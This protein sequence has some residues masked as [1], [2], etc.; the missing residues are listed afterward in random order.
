MMKNLVFGYI[1]TNVIDGSAIFMSSL[2]NVLSKNKSSH[3]NILLAVPLKRNTI[4]K[5][6]DAIKNVAIIDPYNDTDYEQFNLFLREQISIEEAANLIVY[7]DEL[8][9]YNRIFIRSLEVTKKLLEIKPNIIKKTFSYITGITSSKQN[10]NQTNYGYL[11]EIEKYGGKLLCQTKEMKQHIINQLSLSDETIIDLN[12]MIPD[13]P[14]DYDDIFTKKDVYNKFVYTGKFA[15]EWNTLPMINCYRE[16]QETHEAELDVAGDQFK[17]DPENDKFES[18]SRYLLQ[19]TGYLKWYGA[20]SRKQSLTLVKNSDVGLSWRSEKLDDSLELSTKVLEYCSLGKPP[21]INKTNMHIKIFGDDYPFYCNN[22]QSFIEAM[23]YAIENPE[24][25]EKYSKKVFEISKEY[26]FN[27]IAKKLAFKLNDN[28]EEY[29]FSVDKVKLT[30]YF[31]EI[32]ETNS[33][34]IL[35]KDYFTDNSNEDIKKLQKYANEI[36][37]DYEQAMHKL[38]ATKEFAEMANNKYKVT[39]EKHKKAVADY[40]VMKNNNN[41]LKKQISSLKAKN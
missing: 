7:T 8:N 11:E 26:T 5:D 25:L 36:K 37:K 32:K 10:L 2:C 3:T 40:N 13:I 35:N 1:N 34:S 4:L 12:P 9:E 14:Y 17:R 15:S 21:I 41:K 18:Y 22:N 28:L 31:E 33:E 38:K 24:T 27:S 29:D 6:L 16:L 19:N 39:M 23:K 30:N 20:L